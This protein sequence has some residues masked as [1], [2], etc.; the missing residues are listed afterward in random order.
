[1]SRGMMKHLGVL[2]VSLLA[3]SALAAPEEDDLAPLTP[4][5]AKPKTPPT[6]MRKGVA[7]QPKAGASP[8]AAPSRRSGAQARPRLADDELAPL[9]PVAPK[10]ELSVRVAGGLNGAVLSIDGKEVGRLPLG[11]QSVVV[12]EHHVTV[13]RPGY[14]VFVRK[15]NIFM[16]GMLELEAKLNPVAAVLEIVSDVPGAEVTVDGRVVGETPLEGVEVPP[17][18]VE[19]VVAKPGFREQRQSLT[20]ALG[21][22]YPLTVTLEPAPLDRPLATSL[23]PSGSDLVSMEL[24]QPAVSAQ[25]PIVKKWYFWVGVGLAVA[26]IAA[27]TTAGLTASLP[28]RSATGQEICKTQCDKCIGVLNCGN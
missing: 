24:R 5:R 14:S 8:K 11:A 7:P 10:G 9:V 19:V 28:P 2:F 4:V 23:T 6:P 21:K 3:T 22:D 20:V 13:A 25:E 16:G 18:T 15:V 27:A 26:G 12:G 17:G 1:V